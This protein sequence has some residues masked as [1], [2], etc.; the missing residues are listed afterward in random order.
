VLAGVR[1][2]QATNATARRRDAN[3]SLSFR[4]ELLR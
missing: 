1:R 3:V 2:C 4:K